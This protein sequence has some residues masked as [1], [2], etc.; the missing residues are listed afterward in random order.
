MLIS[1]RNALHRRLNQAARIPGVRAV[2]YFA[3]AT[4]FWLH[5][6]DQLQFK[7]LLA[8]YA[9]WCKTQQQNRPPLFQ[10][11][12][13][14]TFGAIQF[15]T[16]HIASTH[17]VFE[18]GSGG[19]TF[20]FS[21]RAGSVVSVEHD[22]EWFRQVTDMLAQRRIKNCSILHVGPSVDLASP[23]KDPKDPDAYV[24][25]DPS[26]RGHSFRAYASSIDEYPDGAF[27][28][29]LID[30]RARPSCFQHACR[31]LS[32][33]G[34][35]VLDNAERAEYSYIRRTLHETKWPRQDFSGGGPYNRH[36]W[37][38]TIWIRPNA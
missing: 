2:F 22:V 8:D 13:W 14:L 12:P 30:G 38:T 32:P 9:L 19:S 3:E 1:L 26:F 11:Q 35:M 4:R 36:F 21:A 34:L 33:G 20:F 37:R 10:Q 5:H 28:I 16:S 15:L 18:Y 24:S 31:K 27:D 29:I 6:Q 17:R 7:A 25:S 23:R